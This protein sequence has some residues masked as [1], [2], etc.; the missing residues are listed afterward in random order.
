MKIGVSF[1]AYYINYFY[2]TYSWYSPVSS[3]SST[4]YDAQNQTL[5]YPLP[6]PLCSRLKDFAYPPPPILRR[7]WLDPP[8]P[9]K[10]CFDLLFLIGKV[11]IVEKVEIVNPFLMPE[12]SR[13]IIQHCKTN[14]N[15]LF[16]K[17]CSFH[18]TKK[19]QIPLL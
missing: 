19:L 5:F 12:F 9:Q 13:T 14:F 8:P 7:I 1:Y 16:N 4:Y 15:Q 17:Y 18:C 2:W 6:P 11:K 10:K 3:G